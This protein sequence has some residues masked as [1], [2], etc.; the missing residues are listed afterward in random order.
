MTHSVR[1]NAPF[2][3][4]P[5][6]S[7]WANIFRPGGLMRSPSGSTLVSRA[8]NTIRNTIR[9]RIPERLC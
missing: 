5:W 1:Q 7:P 9:G 2:A 8:R 3:L 6:L 4:F